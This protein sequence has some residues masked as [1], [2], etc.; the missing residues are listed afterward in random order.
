MFGEFGVLAAVSALLAA[1]SLFGV[2][3]CFV[4]QR[5]RD[6]AVRLAL[7]ASARDIGRMVFKEGLITVIP[8]VVAGVFGGAL[9]A[10]FA[11]GVVYG[12]TANPYDPIGY[13][14]SVLLLFTTAVV[15]LSL[16]A[17]RARC[18][19]VAEILRST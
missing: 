4:G 19:N 15:G 5:R 7:G 3:M 18:V 13:G 16:P 11:I 17:Y 8:G 2:F 9:M 6:I 14:A 12:I 1:L 10:R